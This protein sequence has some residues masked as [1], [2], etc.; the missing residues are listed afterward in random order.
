MPGELIQ[1]DTK[2]LEGRKRYQYTA[3]D[4]VSKWRVL[5]VYDKLNEKNSVDFVSLVLYKAKR[6]NILIQRIQTDNGKEFQSSLR[7]YLEQIGIKHQYTWIHTPDQNGV[8]ERSHRTDEEEFYQEHDTPP[9]Y[10]GVK[11]QDCQMG[12]VLQHT[13]IALCLKL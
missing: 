3:I 5:K 6:K 1:I 10:R 12:G 8:V 9:N 11:Y 7:A 2:Y 4:V 13:K